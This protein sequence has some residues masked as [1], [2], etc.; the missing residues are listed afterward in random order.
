VVRQLWGRD[1]VSYLGPEGRIRSVPL[2]WTDLMPS[3]P[4]V[5]VAEGRAYFRVVDLLALAA[6]LRRGRPASADTEGAC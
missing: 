6:S 2:E 1:R 3:D 4:F 5:V